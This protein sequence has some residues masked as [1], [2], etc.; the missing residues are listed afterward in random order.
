VLDAPKHDPGPLKPTPVGEADGQADL[1][2]PAVRASYPTL[3]SYSVR[4]WQIARCAL[5]IE[6]ESLPAD[7][8]AMD[9]SHA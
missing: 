5:Q 6:R 9:A 4:V 8:C 1:H 7:H 2:L 3:M